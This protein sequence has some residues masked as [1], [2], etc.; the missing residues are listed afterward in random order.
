MIHPGW[1]P[2]VGTRRHRLPMVYV[3]QG[4]PVRRRL[5]FHHAKKD[6]W[7][8]AVF[9]VSK[10]ENMNR[11]HT[12]Y[13]ESRLIAMARDTNRAVLDNLNEPAVPSMSEMDVA[14][15]EGFLDEILLCLPVLGIDVFT[16]P[17]VTTGLQSQLHLKAKG[18]DAS[19]L[20]T[21]D[22]F[23]VLAGAQARIDEVPSIPNNVSAM[24][25][26]LLERSILVEEGSHYTRV[27]D[28]MF[29]SP[30]MAASFLMARSTNGRVEWKLADGRTL[31]TIQ[32]E[33]FSSEQQDGTVEVNS[34]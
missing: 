23:M 15:A 29:N 26:S 25:K 32:E 17:D 21:A 11:A 28:Y 9:F 24:R 20:E 10:D 3:G 13:L 2:F 7:T 31:K 33:G 4:A 22:G 16:K 5:E 1:Y 6:F 19:G 8:K 27:Q 30:S 18:A 34:R 12:G 14:D